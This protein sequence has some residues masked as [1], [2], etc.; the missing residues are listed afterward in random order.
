MLVLF[1]NYLPW[2][3][4]FVSVYVAYYFYKK[5]KDDKHTQLKRLGQT[6]FGFVFI[7]V[8]LMA[9]TAGFI[10]KAGVPQFYN[11]TFEEAPES[12]TIQDNLRSPVRTADESEKRF[13]EL[14]DWRAAKAARE[15]PEKDVD[16]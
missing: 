7:Q 8:T 13:N 2:I 9:L 3:V 11:P 1:L 6:F 10:P 14:I 12:V 5:Y 15:E 4:L 16:K